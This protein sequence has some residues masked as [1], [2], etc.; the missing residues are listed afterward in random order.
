[1][2]TLHASTKVDAQGRLHID[3]ATQ[4]APG[5]VQV[6]VVI[7]PDQ[8]GSRQYDFSDIAGKLSWRG[9]AVVEQRR[10]RDEW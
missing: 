9:D 1:M 7:N 4:L 5:E 6:I 2:T 3:V 8:N 10:L